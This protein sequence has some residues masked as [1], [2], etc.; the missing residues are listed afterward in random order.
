MQTCVCVHLCLIHDLIANETCRNDRKCDR[1]WWSIWVNTHT[2]TNTPDWVSTW[3][4]MTKECRCTLIVGDLSLSPSLVS[5][6][7]IW[8]I[9]VLLE[10][11]AILYSI[12]RLYYFI[13]LYVCCCCYICV[14]GSWL[15]SLE[16]QSSSITHLSM[17]WL[18]AINCST[19]WMFDAIWL[20]MCVSV[21][22]YKTK[23]HKW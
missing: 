14:K 23:K 12:L 20:Y 19:R 4:H 2:H 1:T 10:H 18:F 3:Q 8:T 22:G 7:L 6:L 13:L 5:T 9:K 21:W 17:L 15:T 16:C 11:I